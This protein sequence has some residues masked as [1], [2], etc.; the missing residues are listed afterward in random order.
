MRS[1]LRDVLKTTNKRVDRVVVF[2]CLQDAFSGYYDAEKFL[3]KEGLTVGSMC[4]QQ[5][6]A[7]I[8][9]ADYV[10]KWKNIRS[11]EWKHIDALIVGE[12]Y[13]SKDVSVYFLAE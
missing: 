13:R 12:D 11:N 8:R 5:P 10:G 3:K 2:P 7:A 6:T 9:G 4:G 1:T